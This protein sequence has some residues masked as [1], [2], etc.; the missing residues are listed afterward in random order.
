VAPL[1]DLFFDNDAFLCY[2][3]EEECGDL[4]AC[5]VMG[6]S[7]GHQLLRLAIDGL[8]GVTEFVGDAWVMCGPLYI[9]NIVKAHPEFPVTI[10]PSYHFIPEHGWHGYKYKGDGKVYAHHYGGSTFNIYGTLK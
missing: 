1:D 3:N 10:Y 5:C 8:H 6:F 9:T 4:L 7:E 2:E